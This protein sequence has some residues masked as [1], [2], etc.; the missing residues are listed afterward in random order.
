MV[1]S[2]LKCWLQTKPGTGDKHRI[3][4][5]IL[6]GVLTGHGATARECIEKE[7]QSVATSEKVNC[8]MLQW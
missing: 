5:T 4:N 6:E 1:G 2:Y 8:M 3:W 7:L